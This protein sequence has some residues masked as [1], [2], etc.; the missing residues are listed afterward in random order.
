MDVKLV[1]FRPD[2]R[3]KDLPIVSETT[4][5]GRGE[6]CELQIPLLAVSRRHCELSIVGNELEVK[7]LGSSNGTFVNSER[8]DDAALEAGD[9]LSV[10]PVVFTVQINGKPEEI[11][12]SESRISQ[13]GERVPRAPSRP[14]ED[15]IDLQADFFDDDDDEE[16]D[17][18]FFASLETTE[19]DD[20]APPAPASTPVVAPEEGDID[21]I[22]ALE[23]MVADDEED[24][25]KK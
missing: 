7:D 6:D 19:E 10:G 18:D 2:G 15:V 11:T 21:P 25:D 22:A 8:I 9:R 12:A 5:V 17:D 4:V 23:A 16:D 14:G 20:G 1:M 13:E 24:E 3:R